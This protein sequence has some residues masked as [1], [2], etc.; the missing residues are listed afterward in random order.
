MPIDQL[1]RI[2]SAKALKAT[3]IQATASDLGLSLNDV[4]DFS[5][6]SDFKLGETGGN[7]CLRATCVSWLCDIEQRQCCR[8]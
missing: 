2:E 7:D 6:P 3:D 8:L 1:I 5:L 4:E